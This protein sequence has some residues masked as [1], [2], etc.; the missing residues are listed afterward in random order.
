VGAF[1]GVMVFKIIKLDILARKYIIK[2]HNDYYQ[3]NIHLFSRGA[4][5]GGNSIDVYAKGIHDNIIDGLKASYIRTLKTIIFV[6]FLF[7]IGII[8]HTL[9]L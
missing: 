3:K 6:F 2:N 8:V 7:F 4:G 9:F 1:L 5:L